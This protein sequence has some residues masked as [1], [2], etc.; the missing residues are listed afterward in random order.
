MNQEFWNKFYKDTDHTGRF[1]ITSHRTG[2]KYAVEVLDPRNRPESWGDVDPATKQTTGSYG[3]KYKGSI[4]RDE[5][6]ITEENG[7]KNITELPI[8]TSPEGYIEWKDAQYPD[9]KLN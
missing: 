1:T 8:G 4:A 9:K 3:H 5:S 6:L 2:V 7:F